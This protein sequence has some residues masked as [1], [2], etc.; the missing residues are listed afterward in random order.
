MYA[1]TLRPI[2]GC[3]CRKFGCAEHFGLFFKEEREKNEEEEGQ[4]CLSL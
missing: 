4:C 2:L 3:K 1:C